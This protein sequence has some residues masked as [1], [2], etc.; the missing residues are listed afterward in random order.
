MSPMRTYE[1]H[2]DTPTTR[3]NEPRL[4]RGLMIS[5][6]RH[7]LVDCCRVDG[8]PNK[9]AVEMIQDEVK[10]DCHPASLR[11]KRPT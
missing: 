10:H 4:Q 9:R 11:S 6:D 5:R 1:S 2:S 8:L 7:H 3:S